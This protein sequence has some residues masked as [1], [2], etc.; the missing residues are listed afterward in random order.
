MGDRWRRLFHIE[1]PQSLGWFYS[2]FTAYLGFHD[3]RDEGKLM[4]AG[5]PR[6]GT[7]RAESLDRAAERRVTG[8]L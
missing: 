3:N 8:R 7:S 6:L 2:G 4:G 5:G 1:V